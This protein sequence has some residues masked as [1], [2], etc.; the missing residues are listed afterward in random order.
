MPIVRRTSA[1]RGGGRAIL[2][3]AASLL[4]VLFAGTAV[5]A[6]EPLRL[7]GRIT[8]TTGAL[9][10]RHGEIEAALGDLS[11]DGVDLFVVYVQTTLPRT[12]EQFARETAEM[13]SLGVNDALLVVALEDRTDYIWL[14][15]GLDQVT[16]A[17]LNSI[18]GMQVEPRLANGDFAGAVVAAA[19]GLG[20]AAAQAPAPGPAPQPGTAGGI[21]LLQVLGVLLVGA[22][23]FLVARW[24][25][26]WRARRG[27]AEER[28]RRTG[29]LAK[30]A[31]QLLIEAD[32]AA[33]EAQQEL[34]FAEAQFSAQEV[35]P[36][37]D[38]AEQ[39][40]AETAAAFAIRQRLD[41]ATPEDPETREKLLNEMVQRAQRALDLLATQRE[42]VAEI[43]AL[44]RAAPD[45]LVAM[46][47]RL[48]AL[49]GAAPEAQE[50]LTRLSRFAERTTAPVA[51][52]LVEIQKRLA[53][54]RQGLDAGTEAMAA[55][56]QQAA[57][58][59]ARLA[60][61]ALLEAEQL[62]AA[63][64]H[65]ETGVNEAV[66]RLPGELEEAERSIEAARAALSRVQPPLPEQ[67][68]RLSQ[69][70]QALA[71]ARRHATA[72]RPDPLAAEQ[73]ANEADKLSDEVL[74]ATN[75]EA[76]RR[77]RDP[78]AASGS[79][80]RANVNSM[81]DQAEDPEKMLDQLIRDFTS[82]IAEAEQA[83]AQTVGNL[84]LLE[85]DHREAEKAHSTSGAQKAAAA[86]RKAEELRG[87]G[88]AAEAD[89]FDELAKIA[90]RRQIS[91]ESQITTF[92]QQI[93][94]QTHSPTSSRMAS[95]SCASSAR[96]WC[97]SATSWSAGPRWRRPRRRSSRPSRTCR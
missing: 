42:R 28:D 96:S 32:D 74:A 25:I 84:R 68:Q 71:Q 79:W 4:V 38:A 6:E 89:R 18:I 23:I 35:K 73:H 57:G 14:S 55:G 93:E 26:G 2:G 88:N 20:E 72:A 1:L 10:G 58:R 92:R 56:D 63:I 37:R 62:L 76:E 5:L 8:D 13:N 24:I 61:E 29:E 12:A 11:D 75:A 3:L 48:E 59:A 97:A 64:E 31:N 47:A 86:S 19:N 21:G 22:G 82:N 27:E 46:P 87:E 95:T 83:V 45:L 81:L 15:D 34:G 51:G 78:S 77:A 65:L 9:D 80:M 43:R 70:E 36:F 49:A 39:A 91:F 30:R 90:L 44:E 41:D 85:D 69:A 52:N 53:A 17:E 94:Q 66:N 50:R 40:R 60:H 67:A 33:N 54:A 16:D 7:E